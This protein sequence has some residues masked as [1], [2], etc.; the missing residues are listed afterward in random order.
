[1]DEHATHEGREESREAKSFLAKALMGKVLSHRVFSDSVLYWLL[2]AVSFLLPLFF[3]PGQLVAP[4]FS[5]MILLESVVL[6]SVFLYAMARLRDGFIDIP[7]SVLLLV[8]FLLV[9]QFIVS[10]IVSP[11]PM[12]SFIGSGYDMG[13]VNSFVM[14]F[15]L[16]FVAS[17]VFVNRD[18]I[19]TLYAGLILSGVVVL[20]YHLLRFFFG[21]SFLSFGSF[22]SAVSSPVGK[23]N[24]LAS[25]IG[26]LLLLVLSGL[27]FFPANKSLR[28]P[29]YLIALV[30]LFFLIVIDFTIL[31]FILFVMTGAMIALSLYEGEKSHKR[32][33]HEAKESGVEHHHKGFSRR[34]VGHLPFLALLLFVISFVYGSGLSAKQWT[35][36]GAQHSVSELVTSSLHTQPY[37]EVVLTPKFTYD[38]IVNAIKDSPLFGTGPNRF[39]DGYLKYKTSDMNK[40]PFWDSTFEFGIGRIPTYFGTTGLIGTILWFF[41]IVLLIVKS[42]KVFSLFAKDR[43]AAFMAFSLFILVC[44][45]WSLAFFYLPNIAIFALAFLF[46]GALIA[47]LV[48]EGVLHKYHLRFEGGSKLS[49]V[50]TPVVVI[51][52]VGV[53]STSVLLYRQVSSLIAFRDAQVALAANNI[54]TADTELRT[55]A[56]YSE[57][58]IYFRSLS[59]VALLKLQQL[60]TA[61]V[62]ADEM[63]NQANQLIGDARTFAE[64]ARALDP[65]N[66]ENYLQIGGVYDTLGA[67]GIQGTNQFARE[68]YEQALR[69]NP[70]S[71][72]ILFVLARLEYNAGNRA[73]AKEY[74]YQALRERPNFL[75]ALSFVVQLEL[76]DKNPDAAVT[77]LQAGIGAEP[78]NFLMRF[79]LGYLFYAKGDYKDS[80]TEFEAAVILNPVYADAKY[81]L[82][83]SYAKLG[84]SKEAI[85]QFTD[86]QMLNPDNKEVGVILRNLKAG[87]DPFERGVVPSQQPVEDALSGL[88]KG[89]GKK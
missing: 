55:A 9:V 82:G 17:T 19:L 43:I 51:L 54:A 32:R 22:M 23:W 41:F 66:F 87:N 80:T 63:A 48:G 59:N 47:F 42:R 12:L 27:Y 4:E 34:M 33:V 31:W 56:T 13:T 76:Q 50:L 1:M 73:K 53:I 62:S 15:F 3:I 83:L 60:T 2:I 49:V 11:T 6:L 68:N 79:A 84:R 20:V 5:K 29:A 38:I 40:T 10:A 26:A 37:S 7:K 61:K 77:A 35:Y 78:T 74:L 88:N 58:D 85:E 46:T 81:F 45:F 21:E 65:T 39:A 71:P 16:M 64:K 69:L 44:Y 72:R 70:K 52:I 30:G 28:F 75:E 57:R 25:L 36:N 24:D 67:L 89:E 14:L 8:S 86:V 18:R